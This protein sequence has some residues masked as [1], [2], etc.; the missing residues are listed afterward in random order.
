MK[1]EQKNM[2]N[3]IVKFCLCALVFLIPLFFLPLSVEAFEFNKGYLLFF[4]VSVGLLAWLGKMVF[5]DK[6]IVFRRTPLDLFVLVYLGVMILAT[7]FSQ[8]KITSLYGYYGRFWPS[9]IG[10][11]S[12]G[13]FYFLITNNVKMRSETQTNDK[14]SDDQIGHSSLIKAFIWSTSF[15]VFITYFSLFG[16]W[17]K[18]NN[19]LVSIN[20]S[21]ALP[22]IMVFRGF[23]PISSSTE[24][25]GIFLSIVTVFLLVYLAF[26]GLSSMRDGAPGVVEK[27]KA[28]R[29][30][31]FNY[32]LILSILGLLLIINFWPAW[33]IMCLSLLTFLIFSFRKRL[34]KEDV[35]HL[36]LPILFLLIAI[37]YIFFSP[38]QSLFPA[39]SIVNNL[40]SE[41]LPSQKISWS[42]AF[43][44]IKESPIIGSGLGNYSYLFN[45]FKPASFLDSVVWQIR[46]DKPVTHIAE[47]LGTTGILGIVSYLLLI[48]M[49][50][51]VSFMIVNGEDASS[52][53]SLF[54]LSILLG[55][56]AL[57]IG[58]F[59]YYQ[60]TTLTFT[61]W[62]FLAF[63]V[64][65]WKKVVKETTFSF[66]DFPEIGLI[67]TV[68]FW[69]IL[70]GFLFF[71]FTMGK[72]YVA[73]VYYR[74]Y[75]T[76]PTEMKL[77]L[78]EANS[79]QKAGQ[80]ADS[81]TVY[82]IILAR[83]YLSE[84]VEEMQ[85]PKPDN[86]RL[87]DIV[88]LAV[89]EGKRAVELSPNRVTA[90]ETLGFVYRDIRGLA[91]GASK[92]GIKVLEQAIE[93]EP[94][95]P[96]LISELAK[97]YMNNEDLEKAKELF[98]KALEIKS[99][100]VNAAVSLSI[101]KENEGNTEEAM[102]LMEDLVSKVP[103]SVDARFQ[104]GRLYYNQEQYDK[105]IKQFE[106]AV[107]LFPNHSNSIYSLGLAYQKK[108]DKVK[109]LEMFEKVLELNP[110]NKEIQDKIDE[111]SSVSE[112]ESETEEETGTEE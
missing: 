41:I 67:C 60:D 68:I 51:L 54:T 108:G 4:L 106:V 93:L 102:K 103:S 44:G 30:T 101:L 110:G 10:I 37:I 24:I 89:A 8:D 64:I 69:T 59:F 35:S 95:N 82:H 86:Q 32:I 107:Q 53:N 88:A 29:Q 23:N 79:L 96:I 40:P 87:A 94:K 12:L 85:K 25:L 5:K 78:E 34:F 38:L 90:Q 55:F 66:K 31:I 111:I 62:F 13:G 39:N 17:T 77:T 73:D 56:M 11:L 22:K 84:L 98:T 65:S 20:G 74:D 36:S 47:L 3:K 6:K 99:D 46:F 48:G 63:G 19:Y 92:W 105:A 83:A 27:K 76:N 14:K 58:Q 75:L 33:L 57:L 43:Q 18:I 28:K 61:F 109:A 15:V 52:Y 112:P 91:E 97:F 16:L 2:F 72:L 70:F 45:K 9:L 21:L 71:Y 104:F 1:K 80:I 50:L 26:K 81:R 49:F 7:V 42:I 100:Y